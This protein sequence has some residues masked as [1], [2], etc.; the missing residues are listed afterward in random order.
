M[1]LAK[2][3]PS[4]TLGKELFA[5]CLLSGTALTLGKEKL[6]NG[7]EDGNGGFAECQGQGT[8]QSNRLC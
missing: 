2:A 5:E 1:H 8:P 6:P 3:L 4:A 7:E